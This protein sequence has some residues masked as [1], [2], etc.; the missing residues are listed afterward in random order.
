MNI[1]IMLVMGQLTDK[2]NKQEIVTSNFFLRV[3]P[4]MVLNTCSLRIFLNPLH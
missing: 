4:V 3:E 2:I 1:F